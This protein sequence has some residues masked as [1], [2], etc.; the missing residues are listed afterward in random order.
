M[1]RWPTLLLVTALLP[2]TAGVRSSCAVFVG[3]GGSA[4][5]DCIAVIDAPANSPPAPA[6]PKNVDC[7]DG[8]PTCDADG[9]RN[10]R[11]EFNVSLCVNS[12]MIT[13]CTPTRADSL[14]IDHSTDNGD[15]KFDTDF[16]ALQQRTNLLGFPD[17]ENTD[18]CTLQSTITVALKPPGSEGAPFKKGKKTLRLEADGATDRATTD[19]DHMR[20]TCRPEGNGLYSP[21]ELYDGTFDRIRQQV[22]AQ[23]CA[24]SGCHDSNSHKNNMILYPNVA[25]SQI[26]GVTPFNSAAAVAGWQ[27]VF[28]GDPTQS[29][30]YRKV[31]CDLPDMITYGACMPFQRP[32]I[33]Q[34][35]QDII[36]LWIVGDVPCGPA[37]DVGCWVAGTDQ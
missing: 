29:Y 16:Q 24:L 32:P 17:N 28:A 20:L 27:R 23:S 21:H 19:H 3:G 33:S 25:Y 18:D 2:A 1:V 31:T 5:T 12:T 9:T 26:V 11:C 7:V 15:P 13:G 10:A 35:L 36:Q 30:L 22:F 34:Q 14:A 6:S 37:P 4:S 8:D